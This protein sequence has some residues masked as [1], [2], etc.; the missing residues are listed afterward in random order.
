M[1]EKVY[2][3]IDLAKGTS[4]VAVKLIKMMYTI[5]KYQSNY[6]PSRV[7]LQSPSL[8]AAA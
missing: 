4:K 2:V 3:G 8:V 1:K 5:L 7:F 6:E